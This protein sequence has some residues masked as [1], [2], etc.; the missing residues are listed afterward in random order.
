MVLLHVPFRNEDIELHDRK[1]YQTLYDEHETFI[2]E[3]S[4]EFESN[5]DIV[6]V[7]EECRRPFTEDDDNLGENA[8]SS[9]SS[10][11][12]QS[13]SSPACM[14]YTGLTPNIFVESKLLNT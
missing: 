12:N 14:T 8:N 13:T 4:K 10:I 6:K 1:R 7:T 2:M 5:L 11:L 9:I 3:L